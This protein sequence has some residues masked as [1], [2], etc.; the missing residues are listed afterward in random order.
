MGNNE[1][2]LKIHHQP[3]GVEAT[4]LLV[5]LQSMI[6]YLNGLSDSLFARGKK[7]PSWLVTNIQMGDPMEIALAPPQDFD[8]DA[9]EKILNAGME[10]IRE[11]ESSGD[12]RFNLD[13]SALGHVKKLAGAFVHDGEELELISPGRGNIIPSSHLSAHVNALKKNVKK[14]FYSW[15]TI[16]G[17][18]DYADVH[19]KYEFKVFD[20]LT[21][22]SVKCIIPDRMFEDAKRLLG[23]RVLVKGEIKQDQEYRITSMNV[24]EFYPLPMDSIL[25][26]FEDFK[27]L[28]ITGDLSSEDFIWR[29]NHGE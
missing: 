17:T 19:G 2:I 7:K 28:N 20:L 16:E 9:A 8:E 6:G 27:G 14:E 23:Q 15:T 21:D 4:T 18:L 26:Q 29:L 1:L 5:A 24:E 22:V 25:P 3:G 11:I 10:C 12:N 13:R